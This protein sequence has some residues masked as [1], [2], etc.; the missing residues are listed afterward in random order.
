MQKTQEI[1]GLIIS[2]LALLATSLAV[3]AGATDFFLRPTNISMVE[4][5]TPQLS[6]FVSNPSDRTIVLQVETRQA[7]AVLASIESQEIALKALPA[8]IVL[9]A[10]ERKIIRLDYDPRNYQPSSH[11]EVVVEQLPIIYLK[12]GDDAMPDTMLVTRYVAEI[13][14]RLRKSRKQYAMIGFG[15]DLQADKPILADSPK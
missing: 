5:W 4:D 2:A 7:R 10:G 3:P 14:V 1:R 6:F 9:R 12:P 15:R 13:E 11:Y 8:Q